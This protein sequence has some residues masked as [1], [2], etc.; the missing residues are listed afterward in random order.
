[1]VHIGEKD[2]ITYILLYSDGKMPNTGNLTQ[3]QASY[4]VLKAF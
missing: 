1:M 3:L 4:V 2:K